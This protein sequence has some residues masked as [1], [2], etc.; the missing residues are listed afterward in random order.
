MEKQKNIPIIVILIICIL[1]LSS[2]IIY[3]KV[4]NGDKNKVVNKDNEHIDTP[5]DFINKIKKTEE[6]LKN[7]EEYTVNYNDFSFTAYKNEYNNISNI[8]I[9]NK[10]KQISKDISKIT[11]TGF[12]TL[13]SYYFDEETGL[14]ILTL[15]IT[16][17]ADSPRTYI[18]AFD[19]NGNIK[20]DEAV[21]YYIYVDENQS[22]LFYSYIMGGIGDCK[23][24]NVDQEMIYSEIKEYKY[25]ANTNKIEKRTILNKKVK[26]LPKCG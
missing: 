1:G 18:I 13:N 6:E 20:L 16:P 9:K 4:L 5:Q 25:Y 8:I 14:F 17:V 23:E 3:D 15:T 26:E 10:D 24:D 22:T 19:T 21:G 2:F 12:H 11:D 7:K